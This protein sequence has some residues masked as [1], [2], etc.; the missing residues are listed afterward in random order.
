MGVNGEA[1]PDAD[2]TPVAELVQGYLFEQY[3]AVE[4]LI[5]DNF[6]LVERVTNELTEGEVLSQN[7]IACL[8]SLLKEIQHATPNYRVV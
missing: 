5:R 3:Q 8:R 6:A 2:R 4:R 7:D 1:V